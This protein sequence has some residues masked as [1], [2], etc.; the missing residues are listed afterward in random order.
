MKELQIEIDA[1][2]YISIKMENVVFTDKIIQMRE[3]CIYV[4]SKTNEHLV[5]SIFYDLNDIFEKSSNKK[6][7][8]QLSEVKITNNINDLYADRQDFHSIK[9]PINGFWRR[10]FSIKA[11]TE[12]IIAGVAVYYFTK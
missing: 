5:K 10:L 12:M 6:Q 1:M 3:A 4:Y 7:E 11:I 9:N 2:A 8:D